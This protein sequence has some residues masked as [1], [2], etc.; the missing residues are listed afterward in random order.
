MWWIIYR[1]NGQPS[2]TLLLSRH[3]QESPSQGVKTSVR[4][5]SSE[6]E[7]SPERASR[8]TLLLP[9][10]EA[11]ALFPSPLQLMPFNTLRT[12]RLNSNFLLLRGC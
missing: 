7:Q 3:I 10:L 9:L 1:L 8:P 4:F 6:S 5:S 2:A 11:V 12:I